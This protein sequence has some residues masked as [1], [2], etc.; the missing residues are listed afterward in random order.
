M[1]RPYVRQH[2]FFAGWGSFEASNLGGVHGVQIKKNI[3]QI[4][5]EVFV[6]IYCQGFDQ[7]FGEGTNHEYSVQCYPT[8]LKENQLK[9]IK[10][11]KNI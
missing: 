7:G 11:A 8:L 3:G 6:Q 10:N 5:G 1:Q 4:F 2:V 9:T